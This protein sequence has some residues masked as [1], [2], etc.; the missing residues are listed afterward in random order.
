MLLRKCF[1]VSSG[2]DVCF[3]PDGGDI[4][5]FSSYDDAKLYALSWCELMA[6]EVS[7]YRDSGEL[8]E[9][10]RQCD[11]LVMWCVGRDCYD[12]MYSRVGCEIYQKYVL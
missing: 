3:T 10:E 1:Y 11:D 5:L 4:E 6:R 12:R 7:T 9:A 8:S 2:V